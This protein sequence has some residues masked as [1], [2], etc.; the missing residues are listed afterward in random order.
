MR[1]NLDHIVDTASFCLLGPRLSIRQLHSGD[2][3]L[4]MSES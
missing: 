2:S 4:G 3:G 1:E